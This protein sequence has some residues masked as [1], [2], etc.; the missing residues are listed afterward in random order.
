MKRSIFYLSLILYISGLSSCGKDKD[1]RGQSDQLEKIIIL[2]SANPA[3]SVRL[4]E[5]IYDNKNRLIEIYQSSGDSVNGE[6]RVT[7]TRSSKCS[8]NGADKNPFLTNGFGFTAGPPSVDIYHFY[9]NNGILLKDSL[10][11]WRSNGTPG[12][13]YYN[14]DYSYGN[15]SLIVKSTNALSSPNF[16]DIYYD[17]L[18]ISSH[19]ITHKFTGYFPG[20]TEFIGYRY[21]YDNK[22]NP[23]SRL[24]IS[25]F[26]IDNTIEFSLTPG[27][28]NNNVTKLESGFFTDGQLTGGSVFNLGYT[29]NDKGLPVECKVSN[30]PFPYI[31]KYFYK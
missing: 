14:K 11:D 10:P 28:S 16:P 22:V 24:N 13:F 29:Y 15:N 1:S 4:F 27:Y 20:R 30:A 6:L 18:A 25:S 21:T 3:K 23:L 19:N 5:F 17:S 12:Y 9:D 26:L 8:Y 31:I 2:D 7:V